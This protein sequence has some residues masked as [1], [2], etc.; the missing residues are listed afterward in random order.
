MTSNINIMAVLTYNDIYIA[1][2]EFFVMPQ[3]LSKS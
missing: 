3:L 1:I 2:F